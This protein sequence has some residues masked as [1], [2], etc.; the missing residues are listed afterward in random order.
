MTKVHR[1]YSELVL[2]RPYA[3]IREHNFIENTILDSAKANGLSTS[4][5][6]CNQDLISFCFNMYTHGLD[7]NAPKK[8]KSDFCKACK[9][10][11]GINRTLSNYETFDLSRILPELD[12]VTLDK[13]DFA[14]RLKMPSFTFDKLDFCRIS[15]YEIR[16]QNASHF[17][18][19][20]S[21][22]PEWKKQTE[23]C[24]RLYLGAQEFFRE[25]EKS[26]AMTYNRLYSL[27][28]AFLSAAHSMG[29]ATIGFQA[30]G[31]PS[32]IYHRVTFSLNRESQVIP[33]ALPSWVL[34]QRTPLTPIQVLRT[35]FVLKDYMQSKGGWA[36]SLTVGKIGKQRIDKITEPF[37]DGLVV[38]IL[39]SSDEFFAA[40]S[41][42]TKLPWKSPEE[43]LQTQRSAITRFVD[44][45]KQSP[46]TLFVIRPH[47]RDCGNKRGT[48]N[49]E[50]FSESLSF[51]LSSISE[52]LE[53]I[54]VNTPRDEISLYD[55]V[56]VAK[57][58]FNVNSTA[59]IH[60]TA[61]RGIT[62]DFSNG[63]VFSYP[64]IV[65][66]ELENF[67][68]SQLAKPKQRISK[69]QTIVSWRWIYF[70][71]YGNSIRINRLVMPKWLFRKIKTPLKYIDRYSL[72]K[73]AIFRAMFWLHLVSSKR[74]RFIHS[75]NVSRSIDGLFS[76]KQS[77]KEQL[78]TRCNK[79]K[80]E[81]SRNLEWLLVSKVLYLIDFKR[82]LS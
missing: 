6:E 36:F 38:L 60:N 64:S 82:S 69:E 39:S 53:N 24:L 74:L 72:I 13:I 37:K 41:A 23:F 63:Q 25:K 8:N 28:N 67:E 47:P 15:S 33:T 45:A 11:A 35:Y 27:N 50:G 7:F 40:Q 73:L 44:F 70:Q 48:R 65:N 12:L 21:L 79:F 22:Y 26:L 76:T 46:N 68:S 42:G 54:Y 75:R 17:E 81:I 58:L 62:V 30:N 14:F 52:T 19:H 51:L 5:I 77:P 34:A 56:K 4:V 3:D 55:L 9:Y 18:V 16:L 1:P 43:F 71:H 49:V 29:H 20:Q 59:G 78:E 31:R 66:L 2:F 57:Y 80:K 10:Q 32:K 61:L